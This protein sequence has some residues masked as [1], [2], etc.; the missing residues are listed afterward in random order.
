[1][2]REFSGLVP[3]FDPAVFC[4]FS[5]CRFIF[6][7]CRDFIG[8][9][10]VLFQFIQQILRTALKVIHPHE[11]PAFRQVQPDPGKRIPG[12]LWHFP[13][14]CKHFQHRLRLALRHLGKRGGAGLVQESEQRI[15][16][17]LPVLG[18]L[19]GHPGSYG[20]IKED[21]PLLP[22]ICLQEAFSEHLPGKS[23][24]LH[25]FVPGAL[26]HL[27]LYL[28]RHQN[29]DDGVCRGKFFNPGNDLS[30]LGGIFQGF[31]KSRTV[32]GV[33]G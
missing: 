10:H 33:D 3:V 17:K 9:F 27:R 30:K 12:F 20:L 4:S 16:E 25:D 24:M 23:V 13:H 5:F 32:I 28:A 21:T 31:D 1:M 8:F 19:S 14:H 11:A 6:I 18:T 22:L 29:A 15:N 2:L 7:F 26:N